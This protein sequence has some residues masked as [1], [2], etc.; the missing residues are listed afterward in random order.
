MNATTQELVQL[1]CKTVGVLSTKS[2][3]IHHSRFLQLPSTSDLPV[4]LHLPPC[5]RQNYHPLH[6]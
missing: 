6:L 2:L 3:A 1:Q 4:S 5:K